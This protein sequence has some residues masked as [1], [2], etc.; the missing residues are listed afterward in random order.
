VANGSQRNLGVR[1]GFASETGKRPANED[2]VAACLGRSGAV[3]RDVVAAVADGVGGHK[4]GREAAELAIRCFIDA[5][6]SLP[7]TLGVRRRASRALEGA[8]SWIHAQGRVDPE[9]DGMS[10]AFSSVILS[11]RLCHV[12]HIGD[13]RAYRLSEGRLERLTKDHIAMIVLAWRSAADRTSFASQTSARQRFTKNIENNPMHSSGMI[14]TFPR[15]HFDASGKSA[16]RWQPHAICNTHQAL[17]G[18]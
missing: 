6:Y 8:N 5:Y 12:I 13:T 15:I 16:A 3:N 11:R 18:R 10:C 2:Y 7:E 14:D 1:V 4:G 17:L 9:L